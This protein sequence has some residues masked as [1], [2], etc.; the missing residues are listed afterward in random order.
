TILT[1]TDNVRYIRKANYIILD[2]IEKVFITIW[3]L[4]ESTTLCPKFTSNICC[5][6][7]ADHACLLLTYSA[8]HSG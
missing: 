2:C 7:F 6:A 5:D 8:T 4:T 1:V 3:I